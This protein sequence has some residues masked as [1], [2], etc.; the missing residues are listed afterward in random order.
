MNKGW[1]DIPGVQPGER[2][3]QEQMKGLDPAIEICAGKS[4]LDLGCA[5]GMISQAFRAHGAR[6]VI[7]LDNNAVFIGRAMALNADSEVSFRLADLREFVAA[8]DLV[9]DIVLALAIVHKLFDP[10]RLLFEFAGLAR[11]RL[12]IRLPL[13]SEGLLRWKHGKAECD[14]RQVMV[15]A[16][17]FLDQV[18]PGP[19][20][21]L[22]QH[23]VR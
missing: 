13:G 20:G 23:W 18:L 5:E 7:G 16:G 17:F 2:S 14:S 1:F 22:V 12:V 4:V 9:S 15:Q 11:E 3:L 19:R 21:E 6:P 8:P 10:G